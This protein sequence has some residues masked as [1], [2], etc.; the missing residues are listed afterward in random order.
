MELNNQG[1]FVSLYTGIVGKG[2][3]E[4]LRNGKFAIYLANNNYN[5]DLIIDMIQLIYKLN[6]I[7]NQCDDDGIDGNFKI[8]T[9]SMTRIQ[10]YIND[11]N[12]KID[13]IKAHMRH[14]MT[15]LNE[16]TLELIEKVLVGQQQD[17]D[18][19]KQQYQCQ[20]CKQCL[21]LV[22]HQKRCNKQ[23]K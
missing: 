17:Y 18:K 12:T 15:L 10:T 19:N 20:S 21:G 9:E 23:K 13:T 1:I 8:S 5:I 11:F 7:T 16:L 4:Q 14:S 22:T 2:E 3:L 6:S